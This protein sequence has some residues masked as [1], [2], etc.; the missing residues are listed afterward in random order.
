M[1]KQ[2]W[3]TVKQFL[4]FVFLSQGIMGMGMI[5]A[6]FNAELKGL[7][8]DAVLESALNSKITMCA[9]VLGYLLTIAVFL[10]RRY[11][12]LSMGRI[13][14]SKQWT[15]AGMAVLIA[16][17]WM[18]TEVSIL[19]LAEADK[20]FPDEAEELDEFGEAMGGV[21]GLVAGGILAPIAEEIGFRGVLM[22]GL[23]R[24]RC[25][26]WIAIVVSAFVFSCFHGTYLQLFGTMVFG[27]I[28]GWLYWRTRSLVPGM[29]VHM[30]NNSV[31]FGLEMVIPDV[32]PGKKAC[33]MLIVVFLPMLLIGLKWY[34]NY[35]FSERIRGAASSF[36]PPSGN[37]SI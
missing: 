29:I 13:E 22:G 24:M 21:F 20:L 7:D 16:L 15:M 1:K 25:K 23:L 6:C 28:V 2:L 18:F 34:K 4:L 37:V 3:I 36:L 5:A 8:Q 14:R 10:G 12:K 26:P 32:E 33:V 31:A 35:S 30:V 27:I 11:V 9:I 19:L 17:G